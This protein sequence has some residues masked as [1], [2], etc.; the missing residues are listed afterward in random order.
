[1]RMS[2]ESSLVRRN[3]PVGRSA[4]MRDLIVSTNRRGFS[5]IELLVVMAILGVLTA[6]LLPAVQQARAAAARMQCTNNLKQLGLALHLY[7]DTHRSFPPAFMNYG[8]Y[9]STFRFTHGWAPFILPEIEQRALYDLYHWEVPL[10]HPLNQPVVARHL[11]IFQCPS[12][13]GNRIS[14]M[15]PFALFSG[16]GACGD[17]ANT[18]GIDPA[19]GAGDVRGVLAEQMPARM[20]DVTD[21]TSNTIL[22]TEC[23]G[24]PQLWQAGRGGTEQ[25]VEGGPWAGFKNG[26]QLQGATHDGK[27]RPGPCAL[28]CTNL[29]EVYSFH[30]GGANAVF[31]DGHVRFLSASIDIHTFAALVTRAGGEVP[32]DF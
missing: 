32:G 24:R 14:T 28:N 19:L 31:A 11:A 13:P 6:L 4:I 30:S 29:S 9:I 17:Y 2:S 1:M 16:Q 20:A 25:V 27:S 8:P 26:V 22:L 7:H 15:P 12:A 23:A 10:Y 21:G 3:A 5:L 18:L